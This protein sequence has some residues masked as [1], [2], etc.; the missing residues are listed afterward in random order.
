M[1]INSKYQAFEVNIPG[2]FGIS[3]KM[4]I[5]TNV[6]DLQ[7]CQDLISF[8]NS[9][10]Y[11]LKIN[12]QN[13]P[14][15]HIGWK[16][17]NLF[18]DISLTSI[19][20]LKNQILNEYL[21]FTKIG[22]FKSK[23]TLW[24]NGWIN[25]L[26]MGIG[27]PMHC[28]SLHSNSYLS[29]FINLTENNS[30]TRLYPPNIEHM[31]EIGVLNIPNSPGKLAIFPQWVYHSVDPVREGI[32]VSIGF[33]IHTDEAKTYADLNHSLENETIRRSVRLC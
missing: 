29:G 1:V 20:F 19:S 17:Y 30:S 13:D 4:P 3:F 10:F 2:E 9:N 27:I 5:Y 24:I 14:V 33:D 32:R 8:V 28:H 15:D 11:R 6:I 22:K 21:E 12:K 23:S 25:I 26:E 16:D 7:S 18:A 31:N